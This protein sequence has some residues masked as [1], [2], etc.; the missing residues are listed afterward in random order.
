MQTNE[1]AGGTAEEQ[2]TNNLNSGADNKG[3]EQSL[4]DGNLSGDEGTAPIEQDD[5]LGSDDKGLTPG[6]KEEDTE[7]DGQN[8]AGTGDTLEADELYDESE[9]DEE[10]DENGGQ[11]DD[12]ENSSTG[13]GTE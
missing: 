11:L 12:D 8:G 4:T 6:T 3:G 13:A 2:Q 9:F 10:K 5:D 1:Q 7:I